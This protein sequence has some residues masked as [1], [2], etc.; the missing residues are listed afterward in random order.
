MSNRPPGAARDDPVATPSA[1]GIDDEPEVLR[2]LV[3]GTVRST[4]EA[5]FRPLVRNLGMA[6][7]SAYCMI[8]E[9][10][11][12]ETRVRTLALW[13]RGQFL[14]NIEYDLAGT[15]C[16]DILRSGL[17][18]HPRGVQQKFPHD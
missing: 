12:V 17:C 13:G 15:P 16:E 4:G 6:V 14:D 11:G 7:G 1:A 2:R 18:H 8:A 5:F 10:A 3:E 9:L